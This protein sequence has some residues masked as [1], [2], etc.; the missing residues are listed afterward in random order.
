MTLPDRHSFAENISVLFEELKLAIQWNRPSILLAICRSSSSQIKAENDLK[1]KLQHL[2]VRV[3]KIEVSSHSP[4]VF[5]QILNL[6]GRDKIVFFISNIDWGG[7][8]DGKDTYRNLNMDREILVENQVKAVFWLTRTEA[9][10]LPNYA[11]DFWAFRHQVV[12]FA[13]SRGGE[14]TKL[15]VGLL[16][17]H[18]QNINDAS[19]KVKERIET[20]ERFMM[21]LPNS[22]ESLS[23]RIELLYTIGYL[24][25][26]L[27]DTTK[28]SELLQSGI[29]LVHR[30]ELSIIRT[31][32]M[33]GIA[34]LYYE[35]GEYKRADGIYRD[36]LAKYQGDSIL[37][38]NFSITLC[39]L[40]KNFDAISESKKA[41][42]LNATE[43]RIWNRQ[44][45]VYMSAG[46][47]DEAVPILK[48]AIELAPTS[49]VFYES[50]AICYYK[51][52]LM[53]ESANQIRI[54][55]NYAGDQHFFTEL[56]EETIH[57]MP[58]KSLGLLR[59]ALTSGKI[60]RADI[61][62]NFNVQIMFG[63]LLFD[64]P[65]H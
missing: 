59:A 27:G 21:E 3:I 2:G 39:V 47:L 31:W 45:C 10:N 54:A 38:I 11:P 58:E 61:R 37:R 34:I 22:R 9:L 30:P 64:G 28:A 7:G 23:S 49:S 32:L 33:N 40:G 29:D 35:K 6:R 57:G 48:R 56:Y 50:L 36:L 53:D 65:S 24:Y 63:G 16:I 60:S 62:R 13:A 20:Y 26:I 18:G 25:W 15:P 19:E 55:C 5:Q 14:R 42:K 52:G 51:L 12:E 8:P 43:A 41:V 1:N 44:G 46:K 4:F 17:W